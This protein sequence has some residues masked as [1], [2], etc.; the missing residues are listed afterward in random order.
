MITSY[1]VSKVATAIL[2]WPLENKQMS[3]IWTTV[4]EKKRFD[5][6]I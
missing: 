4:I 6:K 2:Y 3:V 5:I 1:C